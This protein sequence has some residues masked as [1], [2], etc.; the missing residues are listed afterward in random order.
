MKFI[1]FTKLHRK[2]EGT[3]APVQRG[4]LVVRSKHGSDHGLLVGYSQMRPH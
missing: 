1:K 3:W 4:G 2:F